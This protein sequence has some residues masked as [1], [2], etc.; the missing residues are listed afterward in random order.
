[1]FLDSEIVRCHRAIDSLVNSPRDL[2]VNAV[3]LRPEQSGDLTSMPLQEDGRLRQFG[4]RVPL[5]EELLTRR[6]LLCDSP[7]RYVP[8]TDAVLLSVL[9]LA[10]RPAGTEG[11]Y[12]EIFL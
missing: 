3:D 9:V 2:V 5:V 10:A 4:E 12:L 8:D 6:D 11:L 1:V 7:A